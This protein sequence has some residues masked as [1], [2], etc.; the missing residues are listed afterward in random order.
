LASILRGDLK[1]F[2][3]YGKGD[4]SQEGEAITSQVGYDFREAI[5][6][7]ISPLIPKNGM[8][9]RVCPDNAVY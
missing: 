6:D 9:C 8:E 1:S 7:D 4:S 3:Q 5:P 2:F